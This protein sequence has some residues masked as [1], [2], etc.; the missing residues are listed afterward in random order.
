V[1][2][3]SLAEPTLAEL[4][5]RV[6]RRLG[7]AAIRMAEPKA[8]IRQRR[9]AIIIISIGLAVLFNIAALIYALVH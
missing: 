2:A 3:A 1:N 8:P 4:Q 6:A 5:D 9:P 7:I